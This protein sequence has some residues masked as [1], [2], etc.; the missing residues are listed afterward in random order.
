[1][2]DTFL[3]TICSG[4]ATCGVVFT[5]AKRSVPITVNDAKVMWAMHQKTAHCRG[6]KWKPIKLK[7]DKIVGFRCE[8]GY[9]YTQKRPLVC[10]SIKQGGVHSELPASYFF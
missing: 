7:K 1:M 6:H 2:L 3:L 4:L 5:L 9:T 8:C 10:R